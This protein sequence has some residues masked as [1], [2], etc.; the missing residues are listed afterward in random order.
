MFDDIPSRCFGLNYD[1]SHLIWQQ[2]DCVQP[3]YEFREPHLPRACQGRQ[4]SNVSDW[5]TSASWRR[6]WS[7][8]GP[9]CRDWATCLEPVLLGLDGHRLQRPR[10]HRGRGPCLRGRLGRPAAERCGRARVSC[11]NSWWRRRQ[12]HKETVS[13][14]LVRRRRPRRHHHACGHC[15]SGRPDRGRTQRADAVARRAASASWRAWVNWSDDLAAAAGNRP[16]ACGVGV[17]GLAGSER[18]QDQVP[19]ES[20]RPTGAMCPCGTCWPRRSAVRVTC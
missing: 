4:R 9:S 13:H 12:R 3:L 2:I 17:P 5:T 11:G 6:R 10:V 7:I 8:T 1:P 19:A 18:G 15:R 14:G 16:V 20:S